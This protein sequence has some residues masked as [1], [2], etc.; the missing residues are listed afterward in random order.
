MPIV[1]SIWRAALLYIALLEF[2]KLLKKMFD[3]DVHNV[4]FSCHKL[5]ECEPRRGFSRTNSMVPNLPSMA[6]GSKADA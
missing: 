3:D 4:T 5:I 1:A 2:H 6:G